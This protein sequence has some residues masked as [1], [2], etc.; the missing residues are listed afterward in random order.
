L[1]LYSWVD[2]PA[3]SLASVVHI[4]LVVAVVDILEGVDSLRIQHCRRETIPTVDRTLTKELPCVVSSLDLSFVSFIA[5]P[6]MP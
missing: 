1:Y 6:L 4:V 3:S 5:C 2:G